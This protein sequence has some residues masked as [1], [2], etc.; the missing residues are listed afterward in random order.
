MKPQNFP[1]ELIIKLLAVATT[2]ATIA[3]RIVFICLLDL[4][5]AGIF[6]AIVQFLLCVECCLSV[7]VFVLRQSENCLII[8]QSIAHRLLPSFYAPPQNVIYN[9]HNHNHNHQL[10]TLVLRPEADRGG[11]GQEQLPEMLGS[12][13]LAQV[14][15]GKHGKFIIDELQELTIQEIKN[16]LAAAKAKQNPSKPSPAVTRNI[17]RWEEILHKAKNISEGK[18]SIFGESVGNSVV[19]N[20]ENSKS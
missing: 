14:R 18:K 9:L 4:F 2:R 5:P 7:L 19:W 3:T 16:R 10:L 15:E 8:I 17:A 12:Q 11:E 20:F 6:L 13:P 1:A